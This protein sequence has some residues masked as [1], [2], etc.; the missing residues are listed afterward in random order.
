VHGDL[1]GAA[2][3]GDVLGTRQ[4]SAPVVAGEVHQV[5]GD[6]PHGSPRAFLPRCIG[7]GIHDNLT[8][9]PPAG[10]VGVAAGDEKPGQSFG[11][12]G[13]AGLSAVAVEMPERGPDTAT[14]L[15]GPGELTWGSA[16]L[17]ILIVDL[18]T[19]LGA[20]RRDESLESRPDS[21][22]TGGS[23]GV[24]RLRE[25]KP[26]PTSYPV[27]FE[28]DFVERRSRL[29]T[30]F[31][32]AMAIPHLLFAAVYGLAFFVV[33]VIAWF[34]LLFTGRWP[35]GLYEFACGYLRYIT[36]LS[37]Y[38][39]L[40]VDQYPPF[41]GTP[42]DSY[43]VRVHI[44]PPLASYSRLKVFFRTWYAIL[45]LVIRYAMSIVISVVG[46]ISWFAIV[47]TG[48]QPESLQNALSFA[49]SYTTRADGLIFLITE[50]YPA[51]GDAAAPAA[52]AV[53]PS[54]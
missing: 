36:R 19:V 28:M 9:D 41:N 31:R 8:Y 26:V 22:D 42:D 5:V 40:G 4:R 37:A 15:Y 34:A 50:T 46:L 1:L 30:F 49:L 43:P 21:A 17:F 14:V 53:Q 33:Y 35:A 16:G 39:Y 44:A 20:W 38:M 25:G 12:S 27:E 47:F 11:D 54:V 23:G 10:V 7:R 18:F 51:L 45:A 6:Q 32:S 2:L 24:S 13:R 3:G 29:T 48:R 52:P